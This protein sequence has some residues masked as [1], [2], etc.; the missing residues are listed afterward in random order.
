MWKQQKKYENDAALTRLKS[1][2]AEL[3]D[4]PESRQ[5][6]IELC[7]GVLAGADSLW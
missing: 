7:R 4:L 1:R 3:D 5:R 2:L 6:W